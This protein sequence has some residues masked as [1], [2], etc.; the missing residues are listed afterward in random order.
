MTDP[1]IRDE[2]LP[3]S[4]PVFGVASNQPPK[5]AH[6]FRTSDLSECGTP[7]R[8]M[9]EQAE[10]ELTTCPECADIVVQREESR[11]G[12]EWTHDMGEKRCRRV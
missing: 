11:R 4:W 12:G 7:V 8:R 2:Q 3:P 1:R 5:V 6:V 10:T 9:V